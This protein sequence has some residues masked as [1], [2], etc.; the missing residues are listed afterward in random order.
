[1]KIKVKKVSVANLSSLVRRLLLMDNSVYL[2]FDS[3]RVW[4]DVYTPTKDVVKSIHLPAK[5]VFEFE[6][7]PKSMVKLSFY[8]G[9]KLLECLRYFDAH[10]LSAEINCFEDMDDKTIYA[11]KIIFRDQKLKIDVSCQ[12]ISLGFTSMT[13]DQTKRAFDV[14]SKDF[15][16]QLSSEDLSKLISLS[17]FDKSELMSIYSDSS[18]VHFKTEGFDIVVDDRIKTS[19]EERHIFKSFLNKIDKETYNIHV[20]SNKLILESTETNTRLALNLAVTE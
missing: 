13:E 16:F 14:N 7:E 11:E 17:T 20:C 12:D 2:S 8:S 18:G 5:D 4:S 15:S 9:A 3:E 6:N 10:H 1:M 19:S